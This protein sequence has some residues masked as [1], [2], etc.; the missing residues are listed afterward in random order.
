MRSEKV[1]IPKG[2]EV[3]RRDVL[4]L[5]GRTGLS[6]WIESVAAFALGA[7][8]MSFAYRGGANPSAELGVPGHDSYYHVKM[9]AML[10]GVGLV[11]EF[12]WLRFC[13]FT[14]DGR[15]F[16]SHHYGFH[17]FLAPFV[18][19]SKRITGD[20]LAGGR[21]ANIVAFGLVVALFHGLLIECRVPAPWLWLFL[22]LLLPYQ[23][24]TRHALVRA[25]TP[26]LVCM[27]GLVLLMFQNRRIWVGIITAIHIHLYLGGV[28]YA[29]LIVG[30]FVFSQWLVSSGDRRQATRLLCGSVI[31]WIV[32]IVTHP[33][34][35]GIF[36]FLRLQIFG[37]GLSPD[38]A[39]GQEWNP[40]ENL[41][42][43]ANMSGVLLTVW[44]VAIVARLRHG[45][46]LNA[47]E[48]SLFLISV[49]FLVLTFKAR[50]FV[51][52]WPIFCLLSSA[53][54]I[55]PVIRRNVTHDP[56]PNT[57]G[58]LPASRDHHSPAV[59]FGFT[60]GVLV[61]LIGFGLFGPLW[62]AMTRE[63][64]E[65]FRWWPVWTAVA[66]LYGLAGFAHAWRESRRTD[67]S[68]PATWTGWRAFAIDCQGVVTYAGVFLVGAVFLAAP[69]W[70]TI[71]KD[72]KSV[73]D[74]PAIRNMMAF[75]EKQ[76]QPGDVI[77][78]DDWDIFPVFFYHNTHNHY[79]VGLD[80]KFTH[81]RQ[82][83]LW[84]KYVKISR[85]QVPA[86]I[87][88]KHRGES[89]GA[90]EATVHVRLEDIRDEF[91]AKFVIT[92]TDHRALADKLA[93]AT[94]FAELIYP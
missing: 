47:K 57:L 29:P 67:A 34:S 46:P 64:A 5:T 92:D 50:R 26:S 6:R 30:L 73:Y 52:Y 8:V 20:Y 2:K 37:S 16:V 58:G 78:T 88:V 41:W 70:A 43:F 19:L 48:L 91:G 72:A 51:E 81:E 53:Y 15:A 87:K 61:L 94:H 68:R 38:I 1:V 17:L 59:R 27:L 40:Y 74:L 62:I 10:P 55:R 7:A 63:L 82:P 89:G 12:P 44:F 14:D 49:A 35:G 79:I 75:L 60:S 66:A 11:R 85:G 4:N 45:T 54:L 3:R 93:A 39:V 90:Q 76:S 32:G 69:T 77:F 56:L 22:F 65:A 13:F 84:E 23:F 18:Q 33:Y 36:E 42:W 71:C 24:F 86:D 9:A 80:P 25:M 83:E 28:L 31:G 21:W